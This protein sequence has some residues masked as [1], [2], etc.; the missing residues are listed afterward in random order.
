MPGRR[1][2]PW[3]LGLTSD[4]NSR[5]SALDWGDLGVTEINT[6]IPACRGQTEEGQALL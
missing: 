2:L 6:G 4:E 1:V 5:E 3:R